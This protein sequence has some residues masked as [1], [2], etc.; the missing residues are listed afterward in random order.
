MR[1][2]SHIY[3]DSQTVNMSRCRFSLGNDR[4]IEVTEWKGELRVDLREWKDDKPTKKGISLTLMRW[5]NWVDY[6]EYADQARTEK[7]NYK[8]HLGGNVYCTI[9]E[10]SAC[11]DIRQ[12]WKPQEEVIPTKKGLYLRPLEYIA[13]KEL[14][15]EIGRAL[16]ELDGV[17]SCYVQSD[18]MNQLGT[19]RCSECNPN[20]YQNW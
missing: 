14:L 3:S 4:F 16:P 17:V 8:S 2:S 15:T 6:L 11:M 18:H 12:Y 13:V 9:T 19:L 20:D 5:K 7:Q 10:G 1:Q